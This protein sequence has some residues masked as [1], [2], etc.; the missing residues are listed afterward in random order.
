MA[1]AAV[2]VAAAPAG[3]EGVAH[4]PRCPAPART[5]PQGPGRAQVP[6][7]APPDR[8]PAARDQVLAPQDQIPEPQ[9]QDPI[10]QDRVPGAPD[11]VPRAPDPGPPPVQ[12]PL[13]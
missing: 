6:V 10:L 9:G 3:R 11:R 1:M 12:V 8:I 7:P 5:H 4:L 2:A 13:L